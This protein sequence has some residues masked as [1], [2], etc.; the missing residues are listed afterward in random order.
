MK[1]VN[2]MSQQ[3]IFDIV[4]VHLLTQNRRSL[5]DGACTYRGING[6]KC[7]IGV[8]IPTDQY[9]SSM[10][11]NDVYRLNQ[12]FP[13]LKIDEHLTFLATLQ[14]IHDNK[15]PYQWFRELTQTAEAYN[16]STGSIERFRK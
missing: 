14:R 8:L 3:E 10:E 4:A 2:D 6:K 5:S 9:H 15:K 7:A 11:H 13:D 12:A 16:L 1:S